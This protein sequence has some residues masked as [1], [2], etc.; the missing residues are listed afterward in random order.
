MS[1]RRIRHVLTPEN[2]RDKLQYSKAL[3]TIYRNCDPKWLDEI[4]TGDE[5]WVH[6]YKPSRRPQ[7]KAWVPK[8]EYPPQIASRCCKVLNTIFFNSKGLVLQKPCKPG[9][10]ITRKFDSDSVLSR[11]KNFNKKA[12][13]NTGIRGIKLVTITRLF[14][15]RIS[16]KSTLQRRTLRLYHILHT[17]LTL[18]PVTFS[19]PHISSEEIS[20]GKKFQVPVSPRNYCFPA[21]L[22]WIGQM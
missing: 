16:C 7:K 13:P 9:E 21:F 2:E 10:T 15:S 12:R 22:K 14:T 5:T 19:S 17:H 20:H 11:V 18:L 6:M 1:A 4:V 3:L 8:G